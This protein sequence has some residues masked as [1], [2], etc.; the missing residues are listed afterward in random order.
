M[1]YHHYI[2]SCGWRPSK[3]REFE[4]L[5]CCQSA[6]IPSPSHVDSAS[7]RLQHTSRQQATLDYYTYIKSCTVCSRRLFRSLQHRAINRTTVVPGR[8]VEDMSLEANSTR[9]ITFSVLGAPLS[10]SITHLRCSSRKAL[11]GYL[12]Y[13][14]LR[15]YLLK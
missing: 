13:P 11:F 1:N 12:Q 6:A 5:T 14:L 9:N 3:W 10:Q 15:Q 2:I 7:A 8:S 4:C